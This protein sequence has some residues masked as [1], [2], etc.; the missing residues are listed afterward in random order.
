MPRRKKKDVE[1]D[2]YRHDVGRY[3]NQED[4]P[5]LT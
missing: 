2:D 1:I 4:V 5:G 3:E